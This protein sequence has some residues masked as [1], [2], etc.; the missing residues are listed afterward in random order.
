MIDSLARLAGLDPRLRVVPG[1][2]HET[3]IERERPWLELVG[4]ERQLP[5]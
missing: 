1:H 3:T 5:G 2:G 4:R